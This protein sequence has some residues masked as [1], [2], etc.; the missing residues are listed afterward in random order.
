MPDEFKVITIQGMDDRGKVRG[1]GD[2]IG[3][4]R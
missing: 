3:L 2:E 1:K 4:F